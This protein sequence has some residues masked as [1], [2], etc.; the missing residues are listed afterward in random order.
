MKMAG[1]S[2]IGRIRTV[3]EDRAFAQTNEHGVTIAIVADGMGGHQAGD[4]ASLKATQV[5]QE[6]LMQLEQQLSQAQYIDRVKGA[7]LKANQVVYE[8]ASQDEKYHGMGTTVVVAVISGPSVIIGHIGDSRAYLYHQGKLKQLTEDHSLVNE[9]VKNGQITPEEAADHPRRNVLIRALGTD[10]E[11]A[12]DV[13]A[14]HWEPGDALLLCTDGLSGLIGD[15]RIQGTLMQ[16]IDVDQKV[17]QL[18]EHAL[19]A[20]GDDNVTVMILANDDIQS[21]EWGEVIT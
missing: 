7:V 5:I 16:M 21:I 1:K 17:E 14:I 8:Y 3:N 2:D 6:E 11:V 15:E 9:L 20:G 4:I 10:A 13:Q 12:V 18:V 19:Q